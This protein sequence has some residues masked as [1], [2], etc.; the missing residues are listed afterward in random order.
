[1][2]G[3]IV[4]VVGSAVVGGVS[5]VVGV[6]VSEPPPHPETTNRAAKRIP[7]RVMVPLWQFNRWQ[8]KGDNLRSPRCRYVQAG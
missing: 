5:V 8:G 1:V 2:V 6:V 7:R 4:V 3:A